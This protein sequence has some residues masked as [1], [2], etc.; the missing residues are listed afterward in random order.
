MFCCLAVVLDTT[1]P[2]YDW[3]LRK[4]LRLGAENRIHSNAGEVAT[5][6][7]VSQSALGGKTYSQTFSHNAKN[8]FNELLFYQ[9]VCDYSIFPPHKHT[10]LNVCLL[11]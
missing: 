7:A 10:Q 11:S 4:N 5:T 3:S 2:E 8:N 6:S 9:Q 1:T